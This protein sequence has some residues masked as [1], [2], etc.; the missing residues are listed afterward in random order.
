MA[1]IEA[2]F[3]VV[4]LFLHGDCGFGHLHGL[5]ELPEEF[6][7]PVPESQACGIGGFAP[8]QLQHIVDDGADPL[9]IVADDV[10]QAPLVGTEPGTLGQQ[11]SGVTHGADGIADFMGNAG[12]QPAEGGELALLHGALP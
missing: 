3:Q 11:L 12:G 1:G 8:G 7:D 10:R 2:D 6:L 9:G 5:A 4:C